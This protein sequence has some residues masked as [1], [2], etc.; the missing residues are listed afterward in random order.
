MALLFCTWKVFMWSHPYFWLVLIWPYTCLKVM[1][2]GNVLSICNLSQL[3]CDSFYFCELIILCIIKYFMIYIILH[4]IKYFRI[5]IFYVLQRTWICMIIHAQ[6]IYNT[7]EC[8][9]CFSR[10]SVLD[11]HRYFFF[12]SL[13]LNMIHYLSFS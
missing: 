6:M 10:L 2:L 5:C 4:I 13:I 9:G 1:L 11:H 8:V 7:P 12:S 3:V